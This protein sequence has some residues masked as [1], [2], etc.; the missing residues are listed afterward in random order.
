MNPSRKTSP[1][2]PRTTSVRRKSTGGTLLGMFIGLVIGLLIALGI[3]W[4]IKKSPSPF[5]NHEP[6]PAT[7]GEPAAG[8]IPVPL[9]GKPGDTPRQKQPL[10]FYDIL[11]GKHQAEPGSASIRVTP[12]APAAAD[13]EATPAKAAEALF[14]QAGAF[15]KT[16]DADNLKARLALMGFDA[17]VQPFTVADKGT[18]QRVRIGPFKSPEEMNRAR[19]ILAQAGVQTTLVKQKE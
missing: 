9:P 18:L 13:S 8:G 11:E 3:A 17:S 7:A 12:A 16:Q 10:E 15:Q 6:A 14:L 4:Y 2:S 5:Q 1:A 19:T